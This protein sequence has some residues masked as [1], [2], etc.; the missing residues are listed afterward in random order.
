MTKCP[1]WLILLSAFLVF[2]L[3][4]NSKAQELFSTVSENQV[5]RIPYRQGEQSIYGHGNAIIK[6]IAKDVLRQPW[7]VKL[8]LT[9]SSGLSVQRKG[10]PPLLGLRFFDPVIRGDVKY[11]TFSIGDVLIPDRV[12]FKI[13]WA[14]RL[15][16]TSFT[17]TLFSNQ[18]LIFGDTCIISEPVAAFD[19][20]V[21]T[22]MVKDVVFHYD[23]LALA[24]FMQRLW[25]I[26][27]YYASV[28]ILDSLELLSASIGLSETATLPMAFMQVMEFD[29]IIASI[30]S[31]NYPSGLLAAGYDPM[32]FMRKFIP[33]FKHARSINFTFR[34]QLQSCGAIA[35]DGDLDRLA[36]YFT[37]RM[38]SYVHRAQ[39]MNGIHGKIYQDYL[40]N[41]FSSNVFGDDYSI[42][43]TMLAKMYPDALRDTL[44]DFV[45][46]RILLSYQQRSLSLMAEGRFADAF[47]LME[48]GGRF[49]KSNS[50]L[51]NSN[52]ADAILVKAANGIYS[53]YAAIADAC[54]DAGKMEMAGE[55]LEKACQY[56]KERSD[57][58]NSDSIYN[59]VFSRLFFIRNADCDRLLAARQYDDALG[60]YHALE[61]A[62]DRQHLLSIRHDLDR[63]ISSARQGILESMV[64]KS[65][66]LLAANSGDSAALMYQDAVALSGTFIPNRQ[67]IQK[68][69]SLAPLMAA[70][71][72]SA[73]FQSGS[74]AFSHR[75]FTLAMKLFEEAKALSV[76]YSMAV[77]P[78]MDSLHR[79]AVKQSLLIK[80][81]SNRKIIWSNQFDSARAFLARVETTAKANNLISDPDLIAAMAKYREKM[82]EQLCRNL[83]D[84]IEVRLIRADRWIAGRNFTRAMDIL[85]EA[86][87]LSVSQSECR[88]PVGPLLDTIAKYTQAATY[89]RKRSD[90]ALHAAAGAYNMVIPELE[91][92][93]TLYQ[94]N[95]L[96]KFGLEPP[97]VFAFL[98]QRGNPLLTEYAVS[99]HVSKS[100]YQSAIIFLHLMKRQNYPERGASA[101]QIQL[102]KQLAM[103]DFRKNPRDSVFVKLNIYTANQSWYREF[104]DAYEGEWNRLVKMNNPR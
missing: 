94:E 11:R 6:E 42:M 57:H 55:Y 20:E 62:Y 100:D 78:E 86:V 29:K 88:Y 87:S 90:A 47:S 70:I 80:L 103:E 89:Q 82:G 40:D 76:Q 30:D 27:D 56:R 49:R 46:K 104:S 36:G 102:G 52:G 24:R 19:P 7:L 37:G 25:L 17:E 60:C 4:V 45:S 91:N 1:L 92:A 34:D 59:V 81:A 66:R 72:Y 71:Q 3:P 75:Q 38:L 98:E 74:A 93:A 99:Y 23:S 51:K 83:G 44:V 50:H 53:S 73:L 84:S 48:N 101:I 31:R 28:A 13:R 85:K 96:A 41:W 68:L 10:G 95:N 69:D 26:N 18:P 35:W 77:D 12:T 14:N 2:I 58:I 79:Q 9:F 5:Y 33:M 39:L 97:D 16:T 65:E 43:E 54:L 61:Q 15:D 8:E 21:D 63:K 64:E 67:A 32:E 22:L